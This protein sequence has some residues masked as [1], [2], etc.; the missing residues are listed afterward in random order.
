MSAVLPE[1]DTL[2]ICEICKIKLESFSLY[3]P[4]NYHDPL[5]NLLVANFK[6]FHGLMNN[7]VHWA[8]GDL[9]VSQK[10][11]ELRKK[12]HDAK[13]REYGG[14]GM[15]AILFSSETAGWRRKCERER[16]HGP[17]PLMLHYPVLRLQ[18]VP[19]CTGWW[20]SITLIFLILLE[21]RS[22]RILGGHRLSCW[23]YFVF[24]I[25]GGRRHYG[26]LNTS[27]HITF[28]PLQL[29]AHWPYLSTLCRLSYPRINI[30][31]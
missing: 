27:W 30:N 18:T 15:T 10:L 14:W 7:P 12:S 5:R 28:L 25:T 22:V 3:R 11:I 29:I 19:L 13:S 24:P 16:C 8:T 26:T 1:V 17:Y 9:I 31:L 2:S 21:R 20:S 4:K 23:R 6:M